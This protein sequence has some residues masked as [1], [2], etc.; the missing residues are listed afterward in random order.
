MLF[1]ADKTGLTSHMAVMGALWM[2]PHVIEHFT[3]KPNL[4][5]DTVQ[6]RQMPALLY[7][8]DDRFVD[9]RTDNIQV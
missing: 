7:R 2:D 8:P 5:T 9:N 3:R 6:D 1:C 4:S